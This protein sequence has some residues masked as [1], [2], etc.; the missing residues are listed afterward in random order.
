MTLAQAAT[1]HSHLFPTLWFG[2]DGSGFSK[3]TGDVGYFRLW[4]NVTL[5]FSVAGNRRYFVRSNGKPANPSYALASLGMPLISFI[6]N[7]TAFPV[8]GGSGGSFA[9]TGSLTNAGTS[10][11]D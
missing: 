11:T 6:G 3:I 5:D 9:V 7:S 1:Q 8:N 2:D 4:I 10:P